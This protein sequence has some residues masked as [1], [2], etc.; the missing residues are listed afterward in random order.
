MVK[1]CITDPSFYH[2][3]QTFQAYL[4]NIFQYKRPDFI[5]FRDKVNINKEKYIERFLEICKYYKMKKAFLNS[6]IDESFY[7]VHLNSKQFHLIKEAKEKK[8]FTIIST[9]SIEEIKKAQKL[10]VDAVTFSPIF[11][12]PNK[13]KPKGIEELQKV[14]QS[15]P[16]IKIIALG[17]IILEEHIKEIE[18]S[19][20]WGFASIRYFSVK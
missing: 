15:F 1:Y 10:G 2:S 16:T 6:T 7:G 8:L 20:A 9:H 11:S 3:I 4:E 17:G 14:V 12:S 5:A 13:G 19:G 18:K